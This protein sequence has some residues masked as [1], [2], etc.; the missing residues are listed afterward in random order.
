MTF[1]II[2]WLIG[3]YINWNFDIREVEEFI[4]SRFLIN[5]ILCLNYVP[6]V[7]TGHMILYIYF[8]TIFF[9]NYLF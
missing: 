7:V 4:W 6:R 8:V 3:S 5:V 2:R 1:V 9:I